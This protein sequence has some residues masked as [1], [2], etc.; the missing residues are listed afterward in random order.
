MKDNWLKDVHD[1]MADYET[2]EPRGLWEDICS[3]GSCSPTEK[4]VS[5]PFHLGRSWGWVS[6]ACLVL[7]WYVAKESPDDV[8][9]TASSVLTSCNVAADE[10]GA[11]PSK[12]NAEAEVAQNV[13]HIT[14]SR[15]NEPIAALTHTNQKNN[16]APLTLANEELTP[17]PDAPYHELSNTT[18]EA[19]SANP[20]AVSL[21]KSTT[22][23]Q[24]THRPQQQREHKLG[25]SRSNFHLALAHSGG[26]N[27]GNR[28]AYHTGF[29]S[30]TATPGDGDARWMDSPLLGLM[31]LNRGA[32]TER[33]V[34]HRAPIRTGLSVS[35]RLTDRWSLESGLSY[36]ALA[37][38]NQEGSSA[39]FMQQHQRLHYVGIPLGA[40][41]RVFSWKR[42]D[43]YLS[44]NALA[45]KCV[46]G[47]LDEKFVIA[48]EVVSET[49]ETIE[50]H[51]LQW[52][53]GVKAGVQ[54]NVTRAFSL[55][56]EP[57]CNYYFDDNSTLET[58]YKDHPIQPSLNLGLRFSLRKQK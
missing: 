47:M 26:A 23:R 32:E 1:R 2:D 41:F 18:S 34:K 7:C 55:Y 49:T 54:Y 16:D 48:D 36:V 57:A 44:A 30:E 40:S 10:H 19:S 9:P 42:L 21:P 31:D 58:I 3:D 28:Q 46:K 45:E 39:N 29:L 6:A 12:A 38:D 8:P 22:E 53:V 27:A 56:A 35:Y 4:T 13:V 51:P 14:K 25:A 37:S 20:D 15:E 17:T 5:A 43:L 24:A 33:K 52:S 11:A 50:A